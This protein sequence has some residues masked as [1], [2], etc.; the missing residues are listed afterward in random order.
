MR[1][2]LGPAQQAVVV[3]HH[4]RSMALIK[5]SVDVH[6]QREAKPW[7]GTGW[8]IMSGFECHGGEA[9]N[10]DWPSGN[11]PANFSG[12]VDTLARRGFN[13]LMIY[14]AI[15]LMCG[16]DGVVA[17]TENIKRFLLPLMDR[18]AAV[19]VRVMVSVK[20]WMQQSAEHHT[21]GRGSPTYEALK[22]V[23]SALKNHK[24][25]LG[26]VRLLLLTLICL[27]IC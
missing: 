5:P 15:T 25:L 6:G 2:V 21:G 17:S 4:T 7:M 14:D 9:P 12:I 13:Q 23:T 27:V 16:P 24:A 11:G 26:W 8:Y 3:D 1:E 22:N 10:L 18:M 20:E 19:G